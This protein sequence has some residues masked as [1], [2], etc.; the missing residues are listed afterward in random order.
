MAYG[1]LDR[2]Y[3]AIAAVR[4]DDVRAA[5][6]RYL[7]PDAVSGVLYLPEDEGAELTADALARAFAVTALRPARAR[8]GRAAP[9]PRPAVVRPATRR[10]ADVV[11][12]SLPGADLLVRRKPGVPL[13]HLG[14]YVPRL[15]ARPAGAG[16]TRRA[17]RAERGARRGR[18]RRRRAGV[19]VRA[20]RRHAGPD[21]GVRL[22]RL[23]HHRAGGAPGARPPRCWTWS[24]RRP[25]W[26]SAM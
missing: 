21:R 25:G 22:A 11:H 8:A 23:R 7:Q 3:E 14:I 18:P 5:A 26:R 16:G 2:E 6:A 1:F 13:V 9:T 15:R 24:T 19:R 10:E 20:S 17:H 4:P 12:T